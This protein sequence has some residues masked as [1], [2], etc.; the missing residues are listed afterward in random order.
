MIRHSAS[1]LRP[2]AQRQYALAGGVSQRA[3]QLTSR[4]ADTK[5]VS[6]LHYMRSLDALGTMLTLPA[7]PQGQ[8]ALQKAEL[9]SHN[10]LE[11]S[12]GAFTSSVARI[13]QQARDHATPLAVRWG[14]SRS[15][16][17]HLAVTLL[18]A[19]HRLFE[20]LDSPA[21]LSAMFHL[22]APLPI[23]AARM[24]A[25][26]QFANSLAEQFL[27]VASLFSCATD[28]PERSESDRRAA[29]VQAFAQSR[30]MA[31]PHGLAPERSHNVALEF[32]SDVQMFDA[33]FSVEN[34][35]HALRGDGRLMLSHRLLESDAGHTPTHEIGAGAGH[36]AN[37]LILP[38][39][40]HEWLHGAQHASID[41][42]YLAPDQAAQ[43]ARDDAL[44]NALSLGTQTA[45]QR[46]GVAT[47]QGGQSLLRRLPHEKE[48]WTLS[49][50]VMRAMVTSAAVPSPLKPGLRAV[51]ENDFNSLAAVTDAAAGFRI[52]SDDGELWDKAGALCV[53]GPR[54]DPAMVRK[55]VADFIAQPFPP[56]AAHHGAHH[57]AML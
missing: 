54:V 12:E 5:C 45:V 53:Q 20:D 47:E 48:S 32:R 15:E 25:F 31:Q 1:F 21:V 10:L 44:L 23:T 42:I 41:T 38:N 34:E 16:A 55:Q 52:T 27:P 17:I 6:A 24:A 22:I 14:L 9:P 18:Q 49:F 35:L 57:G 3:T 50:V 37:A 51:M 8:R 19:G 4:L 29:I 2:A 43:A 26:G 13:N 39:L 28:W 56:P 7:S 11:R 46:I 36:L 40:C 33:A 30:D